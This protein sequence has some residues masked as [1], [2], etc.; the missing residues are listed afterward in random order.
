MYARRL[1]G[2]WSECSVAFFYTF[3]AFIVSRYTELSPIV[4]VF[5]FSLRALSNLF[6]FVKIEKV[7]KRVPNV[8]GVFTDRV[9]FTQFHT[10]VRRERRSMVTRVKSLEA[11]GGERR[12]FCPS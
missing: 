3:S 8:V 5:L 6:L 2:Q 12:I 7:N 10:T 1:A 11:A 9:V 4:T